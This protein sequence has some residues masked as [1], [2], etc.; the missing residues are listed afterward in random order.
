[1]IFKISVLH[2]FFCFSHSQPGLHWFEPLA[3]LGLLGCGSCNCLATTMPRKAQMYPGNPMGSLHTPSWPHGVTSMLLPSGDLS[4][5]SLPHIILFFWSTGMSNPHDQVV[6]PASSSVED[7]LFILQELGT[8][9]SNLEDP[10]FR[11]IGALLQ[12]NLWE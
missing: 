9:T 1:M 6:I 10:N 7:Y 3:V 11:K 2:F 12:V 4:G 8:R 5:W